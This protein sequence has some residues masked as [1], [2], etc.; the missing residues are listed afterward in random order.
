MPMGYW[1]WP[2]RPKGDFPQI[3]LSARLLE[4][5]RNSWGNCYCR[6]WNGRRLGPVRKDGVSRDRVPS[7]HTRRCATGAQQ[8][9]LQTD[10]RLP[11]WWIPIPNW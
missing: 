11:W 2:V 7:V 3:V 1:N 6:M 8:Q 4:K 5:Q 9:T 10:I